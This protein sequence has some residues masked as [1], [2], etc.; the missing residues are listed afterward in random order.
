[1]LRRLDGHNASVYS[2]A[3]SPGGDLL[4]SGDYSDGTPSINLWNPADGTL[5]GTLYHD[6]EDEEGSGGVGALSFSSDGALLASGGMDRNPTVRLWDMQTGDE[7]GCFRGTEVSDVA[8]SLDS[9]LLALGTNPLRVLDTDSM[10]EVARLEGHTDWATTVAFSPDGALLASGSYNEDGTI[11][12]WDVRRGTQEQV[13]EGH[14]VVFYVRFS[15]DG[16]ILLSQGLTTIRFWDVASGQERE[17]W[18]VLLPRPARAYQAIAVDR[19]WRRYACVRH[20]EDNDGMA[21]YSVGVL[22]LASGLPV[23][24]LRTGDEQDADNVLTAVAF[25]P[26]KNQIAAAS[27][28]DH[29]YLWDLED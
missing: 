13:L 11:R 3:Y 29:V 20:E 22:D 18:R 12:L 4:A 16:T 15:D 27:Q 23:S 1:M 26:T 21:V 6:R 5:L 19:E 2:L 8:F 25:H 10:A 7:A 9:R 24:V 28:A 14:R 17:G